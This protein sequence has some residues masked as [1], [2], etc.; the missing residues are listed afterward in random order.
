MKLIFIGSP[1]AGKGTQAKIL[2]SHFNL[3]H[4]ST[5]DL[6]RAEINAKTALGLEISDIIKNGNLVSDNI[7]ETLISNK[8]KEDACKNGFILDGYPRNITQANSLKNIINDIDKVILISVPD[9]F[10]IE[11]MI[12]RKS[13]PKCGQMYHEKY[14]S[15]KQEGIC[16]FCNEPLIQREDDK[17]ETVKKRLSVYHSLTSPIIDYYK[18]DNLLIEVDGTKSIQE[19]TNNLISILENIRNAK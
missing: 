9:K 17:E 10:I 8:I 13:C 1:G 2:A 16:D 12:G 4:L 3:M 14:N 7:V 15:P 5:G 19:V 18:K 11:R 6:L